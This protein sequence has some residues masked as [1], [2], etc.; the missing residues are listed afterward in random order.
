MSSSTTNDARIYMM[1]EDM[2]SVSRKETN[3]LMTRFRN[4]R[5]ERR[6]RRILE[7]ARKYSVLN[8]IPDQIKHLD[9]LVH[10]TDTTCLANLR[11]DRNTFGKLC[12]ILTERGGLKVAKC[13]GVE[14]QV[15]I[16][17]GVLAHHNKNR[18]QQHLF[19]RSGA[20]VSF[21]VNKV[22]GAVLSLHV[23]LLTPPVPVGDDF[24]DHRWKWFK[25]CLG[26]LDGTHIN[27]L[28]RSA[29]K[30]RYRTR[31]G[32]IAT[33]TLAVCNRNMQFVYF[34]P[35][36]EGSA[37]DSRVLRDAV[38]KQN[39]FKVPEGCYY[40]CDN[41]YANSNG[42]LTPYK[43]V[44]YHLK[45]WGPGM[46]APQ[47]PKELFNMRHTKARNVIERAFAVLKM[48][49]GILRCASFYP[50]KTQIRLIMACF[51]LHNFIRRE[52]GVDPIEVELDETNPPVAVAE[53]IGA[54]PYVNCVEPTAEWTSFRDNLALNM[55]NNR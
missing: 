50:I 47:N 16:F 49:W 54:N 43:G 10:V 25:G 15:A 29:D 24:T 35:G 19:W 6:K 30:P 32:Q 7:Y 18:A 36:W 37:G 44:R 53:D 23:D 2:L 13:L 38:A 41:A 1:L 40:L 14:E 26:A 27:V 4:A 46:A 9:R 31:K 51:L 5:T 28:V 21:Y 52:M 48:R 39:G 42:F 12:R 3:V 11:M 17:L 33:N 22:L 45:E 20:T 8:K 34:L 55:W